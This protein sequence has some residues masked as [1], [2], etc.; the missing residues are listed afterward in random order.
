MPVLFTVL[1]IEIVI[2]GYDSDSSAL[3]MEHEEDHRKFVEQLLEASGISPDEIG[4]VIVERQEAQ[5][6]AGGEN[7][8]AEEQQ[9]RESISEDQ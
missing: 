9:N 2:V 7:E 4:D 3:P 5:S 6:E 8:S 1:L